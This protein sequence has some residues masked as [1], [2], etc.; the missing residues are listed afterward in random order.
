MK[1]FV[2]L[3]IVVCAA[4]AT[5]VHRSVLR[6]SY[7]AELRNEVAFAV[8]IDEETRP[9]AVTVN[10]LDVTLSGVVQSP[11]TREEARLRADAVFGARARPVDNLLKVRPRLDAIV[12]H[13]QGKALD[14]VSVRGHLATSARAEDLPGAFLGVTEKRSVGEQSVAYHDFVLPLPT[15][16]REALALLAADFA[17]L[18][19]IGSLELNE[20]GIL[21]TGDTFLSQKNRL[22]S[23]AVAAVI[24]PARVE[25]QLRAVDLTEPAQLALDQVPGLEDVRVAFNEEYATLTGT[26]GSLE[27]RTRAAA[28]IRSIRLAR[29]L[30]DRNLIALG[31]MLS[32]RVTTAAD[33]K[34][35][36]TLTGLLPDESWKAQL[37]SSLSRLKPAW[38]VETT[39]LRFAPS[40]TTAPWLEK[41][42]FFAYFDEFFA[43]PAPGSLRVSN[44]GLEVSGQTTPAASQRLSA[45]ALVM[46][47]TAAR[48][49]GSFEVFPS[50]YHQPGYLSVS[51][52]EPADRSAVREA[53]GKTKIDFAGGNDI[54][55]AAEQ[56][57]LDAAAP[58]LVNA[59][60]KLRL[61]AGGYTDPSDP[62]AAA[63]E[64]RVDAVIAAL[65]E[66]GLAREQINREI[67]L[68]T[69]GDNAAGERAKQLQRV[70]ILLK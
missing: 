14:S 57:K 1:W 53:L 16:N 12:E 45:L 51:Q 2:P 28:V 47:M 34:K 43:L 42:R 54:I 24:P 36:L 48:Y 3:L 50:I 65:V 25:S 64:A 30:E 60:P 41:A 4:L 7:E 11:K 29:L 18:P 67:F 32:A 62:N 20:D 68:L 26:V 46:G 66:R 19:S 58:V 37:I 33:G 55:P 13:D 69:T 52:L 22:E 15:F 23:L 44:D 40:L 56:A 21:M 70:E 31:G 8:R 27:L 38:T 17:R 49:H 61:V 6:P 10:Y 63:S 35:H 5:C 9:I 39:A 59:G